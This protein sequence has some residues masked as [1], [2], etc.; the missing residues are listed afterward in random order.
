MQ[1]DQTGF[2]LFVRLLHLRASCEDTPHGAGW[3]AFRHMANPVG[4]RLIGIGATASGRQERSQFIAF[5]R[6]W[7]IGHEFE[8]CLLEPRVQK[9]P[10]EIVRLTTRLNAA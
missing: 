8:D 1:S 4:P 7:I 9:T 3:A 2:D 6:A 5:D 10:R